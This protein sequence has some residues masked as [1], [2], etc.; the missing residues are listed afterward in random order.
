M[1]FRSGGI[2]Y[3]IKTKTFY[4]VIPWEQ[5]YYRINH[6]ESE[7]SGN[8]FIR[9]TMLEFDKRIGFCKEGI[10][11]ISVNETKIYEKDLVLLRFKMGIRFFT[12]LINEI[13]VGFYPTPIFCPDKEHLIDYNGHFVETIE[14]LDKTVNHFTILDSELIQS[15]LK[16]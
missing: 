8:I 3:F 9:L 12:I 11:L 2:E 1:F 5:V 10:Q 14:I 16:I 4:H 13:Y 7:I 15:L 6:C